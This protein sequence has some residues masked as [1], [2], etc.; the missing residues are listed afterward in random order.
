MILMAETLAFSFTALNEMFT[1]RQR[2][3]PARAAGSHRDG[4]ALLTWLRD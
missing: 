3:S 1:V 2:F 4:P